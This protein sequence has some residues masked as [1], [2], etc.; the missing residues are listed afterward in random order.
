MLVVTSNHMVGHD[1]PFAGLRG[2]DV[3]VLGG[4]LG[5]GLATAELLCGLGASV[6]VA[7]RQQAHIDGAVERL[8]G[9]ASGET[10]DVVEEAQVERL[11]AS[12]SD[13]DHVVVTAA[14]AHPT[15]GGTPLGDEVRRT[16]D[17]RIL[18][19]LHVGR[20]AS[21][22]LRPGGSLTFL[23]G[24]FA[25]RPLPGFSA[26]AA[27]AG[28]LEALVRALAR[29]LAPLRVNAVRPGL[30]DTERNAPRLHG[31]LRT[32]HSDMLPAGRVG[33]PA[34]VAL[35]IVSLIANPHITGAILPVDGGQSLV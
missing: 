12:S 26:A 29:D 32:A 21:P 22:C 6:V 1:T 28:A 7:S 24:L 8:L 20:Y 17:S 18:G 34:D 16:L 13:L 14:E 9:G 23:S 30:I 33:Q 27:S 31:A 15:P 11:F 2:Q 10:V 3:L 35:A 5:I 19:A 4:T 25:V